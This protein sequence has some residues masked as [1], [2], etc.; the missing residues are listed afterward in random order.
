MISL[1]S[2]FLTNSHARASIIERQS[3]AP[4]LN[5]NANGQLDR[6]LVGRKQERNYDCVPSP[7]KWSSW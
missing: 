7:A 4:D 1:L 6:G 3:A 5:M 2:V